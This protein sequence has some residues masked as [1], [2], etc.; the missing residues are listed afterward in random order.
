M[1]AMNSLI[2]AAALAASPTIAFAQATPAPVAAPVDPARLAAAKALMEQIMPPA[3]RDQMVTGM[4]TSIMHT[5]LQAMQQDETLSAELEKDP[6]AGPVFERFMQRQQQ[7]ATDQLKTNLPGMLDAMAHAYARRFTLPQMHDMTTFFATPS[8][9]AYL[10][11]APTLMSDPDVTAWMGDLMRNS[12]KRMPDEVAKLVA[13][14]KALDD[15]GK[16]HGG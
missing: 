12:M 4:M 15:K 11:Q 13:E 2:L 7:L 16:T 3:T 8:G 9:Q 14:L 10:V 1:K 5:M 6:R